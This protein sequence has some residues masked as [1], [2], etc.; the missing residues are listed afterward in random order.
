[1]SRTVRVLPLAVVALLLLIVPSGHG[2]PDIDRT[3]VDWKTPAEIKWVRNAAGTNE[4]AVL[5]GDPSKPGPYNRFFVVLSGTWW[6]GTGETFDPDSTVPAPAGSYVIHY[7]N[8]VHYDGAKAEETIIQ[9]W[10]MGPATSTP[11]EKR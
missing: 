8:K 3:A 9:V 1:M 5:F 6:M 10:G 2:A 4:S 7:A 11:A